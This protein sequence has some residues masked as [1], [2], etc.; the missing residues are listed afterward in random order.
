MLHGWLFLAFCLC[1]KASLS[2]A[3]FI[4]KCV[5]LTGSFSCELNSFSWK[6]F[7]RRTLFETEAQGTEM[8]C[9]FCSTNDLI[10]Y[11]DLQ[12]AVFSVTGDSS[13]SGHGSVQQ[14]EVAESTGRWRLRLQACSHC[15]QRSAHSREWNYA[16]LI[17]LNWR[18][19]WERFL[20]QNCL[21]GR[22][23]SSLSHWRW[24]G[25]FNDTSD[26]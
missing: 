14:T 12:V 13:C 8:A 4:W 7:C 10:L 6:T 5:L 25:R 17:T 20:K 18:S 1:V 22:L 23:I 11:T 3:S 21:A 16:F 2:C 15:R 9:S 19:F 24:W 26:F